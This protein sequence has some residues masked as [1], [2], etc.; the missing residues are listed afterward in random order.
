MHKIE[1][2]YYYK[3]LHTEGDHILQGH[4]DYE[5]PSG[6]VIQCEGGLIFTDLIFPSSKLKNREAQALS[7]Q[8]SLFPTGCLQQLDFHVL[9]SSLKL[10]QTEIAWKS[11]LM[12]KLCFFIL[13]YFFCLFISTQVNFFHKVILFSIKHFC[14]TFSYLSA[15][16]WRQ[17]HKGY[18]TWWRV[19]SSCSLVYTKS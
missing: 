2:K 6:V 8:K 14:F 19:D 12:F 3:C 17:K 15:F 1:D 18:Q 5:E 11:F 10:K 16:H 13:F 4:A 7:W 9:S